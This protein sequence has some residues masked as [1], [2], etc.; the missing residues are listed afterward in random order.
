MIPQPRSY[1]SAARRRGP[2]RLGEHSAAV[3]VGEADGHCEDVRQVVR[4]GPTRRAD[5][6]YLTAVCRA[7]M[8]PVMSVQLTAL[9]PAAFSSAASAG[10]VGNWRIE[11]LR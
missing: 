1:G 10:C 11:S 4:A 9:K 3:F 6:P 7:T 2:C 5:S 8:P